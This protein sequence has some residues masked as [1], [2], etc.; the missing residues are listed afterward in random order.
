MTEGTFQRVAKVDEI[1][2]GESRSFEVGY[3]RIAVCNVE[4]KFYAIEDVCTHDGSPFQ[5][6]RLLGSV[7]ECPRHG[8]RFDVTTGEVRRMPAIA[9]V[10][11]FPTKVEDGEVYVAVEEE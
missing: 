6:R 9:P 7:I 11:T 1:P 5:T 4:G 10:R 2:V 8:A 3:E